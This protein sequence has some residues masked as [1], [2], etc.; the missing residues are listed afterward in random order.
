MLSKELLD[1]LLIEYRWLR[2]YL[3]ELL[4]QVVGGMW[5]LMMMKL[6]LLLLLPYQSVW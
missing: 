3:L 4:L 2:R 5:M 6:L 1:E